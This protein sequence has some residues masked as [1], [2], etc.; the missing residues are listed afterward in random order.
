VATGVSPVV[1][2]TQRLSGKPVAAAVTGGG[3]RTIGGFAHNSR[4]IVSKPPG[5]RKPW[6]SGPLRRPPAA[7]KGRVQ[8]RG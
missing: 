4:R 6:L 2:A 8:F 3:L 1:F 7:L 5:E